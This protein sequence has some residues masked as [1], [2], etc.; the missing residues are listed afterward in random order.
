MNTDQID[1]LIT[2]LKHKTEEIVKRGGDVRAEIAHLVSDATGKFYQTKDG[3]EQLVKAVVEGAAVAA[4][5]ALPDKADSV[6]HSV[7]DGLA[8]G[9]TRSA[10]AV[11]LTLEESGAKGVHF[12]KD[13]LDKIAKNFHV[14]G[15]VFVYTVSDAASRIS[16]HGSQQVRTVSEHAKQTLQSVWPSLQSAIAAIVHDPVKLGRESLQAGT[17]AAQQAAGVLF[18]ELGKHLQHAGDKLRH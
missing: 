7:V 16:G 18:S 6:L 12:A 4:N 2:Q 15:E 1:H 3:L 5:D 11:L 9:L 17:S 13:D 10:Q 8:D 14:I